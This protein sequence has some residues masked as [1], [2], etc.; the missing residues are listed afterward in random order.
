MGD[1]SRLL[2][3][4]LVLLLIFSILLPLSQ[5][6][7]EPELEPESSLNLVSTKSGGLID[8]ANWR[9]G[10][11]WIYDSEFDVE[12]LIQGGAAGSQVDILTGQLSREVVDIRY[13]TIENVST[14]VYELFSYGDFNDYDASLA[15]T[16][17]VPGD[18]RVQVEM[19]EIIRAS[20]LSQITYN[21]NLDVDFNNI[22]GIAAWFVGEELAL[23]DMSI[24]TSY[25]PPKEIYDFPMSVGEIWDTETTTT[26]TWSGDVYDNLFELP[27][28]SS[29]PTTERFEV[30]G[31]GDPGV[32]YPGCS[33]AYN[34]TSYN[35][36]TGNINGYRWWCEDARNDAWWHQRIEVG[37][38]LDFR[39]DQYNPVSRTHDLNVGLAFPAWMLDADLGVWANVTDSSGNPV[40]N[41]DVEFRYEIEEDV[42]TVTTAANGSAYLTF[43]TGH[44]M[45][46]SPTSFDFASHGVIAWIPSTEE[47]GV[48][49]ITLDENLVEIDLAAMSSGGS[50]SR[51]RDG[52]SQ[53]LN[54]ITGYYS[55][56]GD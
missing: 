3:T 43:D 28:D 42:R 12:E 56:P 32:N 21:M 13:E 18:L 34:V 27:D 22:S 48:S 2:P 1:H 36:S 39:L 49:T 50:V 9:I 46:P 37:V 40:S 11:E 15:S 5:P 29:D 10:D 47:I 19:E 55:I 51:L 7:I 25:A 52:V 24:D 33:N 35:A 6:Q 54:S 41:Q 31:S 16:V 14:L 8:V 44:G 45:D 17:T 30:V 53:Q 20:D 38:D 26:T 4:S 23:A